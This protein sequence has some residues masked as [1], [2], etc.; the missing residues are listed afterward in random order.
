MCLF[1]SAISWRDYFSIGGVF[2]CFTRVPLSHSLLINTYFFTWKLPG[3]GRK[4]WGICAISK[5]QKLEGERERENIHSSI[6]AVTIQHFISIF[7]VIIFLF[8]LCVFNVGNTLPFN[9]LSEDNFF[10]YFH[11]WLRSKECVHQVQFN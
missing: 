6:L 7:F 3:I 10:N 4:Y 8:T 9:L 5:M 11:Y 1:I 2:F